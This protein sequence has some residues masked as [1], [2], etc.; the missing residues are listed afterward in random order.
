MSGDGGFCEIKSTITLLELKLP[1]MN[2][3]NL[4]TETSNSD[5]DTETSNSDEDTG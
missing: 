4:D 3:L 2:H 5:E 1:R